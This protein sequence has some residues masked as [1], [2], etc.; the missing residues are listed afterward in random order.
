MTRHLDII[1]Y[2]LAC[3]EEQS[4]G[5]RV[6]FPDG[7]SP[8]PFDVPVHRMSIWARKRSE[9]VK[10]S[11]SWSHGNNDF[12]VDEPSTLEITGL[13]PTI[14]KDA[15]ILGRLLK[16]RDSDSDF[17]LSGR[18]ETILRVDVDRG[19]LSAH[20]HG[21]DGMIVVRWR[22]EAEDDAA[23]RF[24]IGKNWI[25]I[26]PGTEQVILAN[27]GV[28]AEQGS[29]SDF[30]IYRKLATEKTGTIDPVKPDKD[31]FPEIPVIEPSDISLLCPFV[32]CSPAFSR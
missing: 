17:E 7:R 24:V 16:L 10:A 27:A 3:F 14:I 26:A 32:D 6:L 8:E 21:D 15:S 9:A 22:V 28:G 4:F 1:F 30:N 23:I 19:V 29:D 25:E 5:Y 20:A 18:P 13:N 11:W 31:P 2:G 12:Q